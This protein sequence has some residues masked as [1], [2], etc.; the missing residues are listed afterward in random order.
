MLPHGAVMQGV[1]PC[2]LPLLK[3]WYKQKMADRYFK[4]FINVS[5]VSN[6]IFIQFIF[7]S[8][9]QICTIKRETTRYVSWTF[10]ALNTI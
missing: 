1:F 9:V 7:N 5:F 2:D 4:S 6:V 3:D 10:E 8:Y